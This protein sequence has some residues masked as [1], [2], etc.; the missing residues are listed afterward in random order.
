MHANVII[1]LMRITWESKFLEFKLEL[2]IWTQLNTMNGVS[3][4][5]Q[6]ISR[7]ISS[8]FLLTKASNVTCNNAAIQFIVKICLRLLCV[9]WVSVSLSPYLW[10]LNKKGLQKASP[11]QH[12]NLAHGSVLTTSGGSTP[13]FKQRTKATLTVF[14]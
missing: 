6:N 1:V 3:S 14:I 7:N 10:K 11:I 13:I 12:S 2:L 9:S 4:R 8:S 5:F